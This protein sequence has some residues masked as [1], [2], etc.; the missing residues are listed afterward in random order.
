MLCDA[1]RRD[2]CNQRLCIGFLYK[3]LTVYTNKSKTVTETWRKEKERRGGK[4]K[5]TE[6]GRQRMNAELS[7]KKYPYTKHL[8][9]SDILLQQSFTSNRKIILIMEQEQLQCEERSVY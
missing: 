1:F 8:T 9:A 2:C 5:Q 4:D 3:V 7:M 6:T